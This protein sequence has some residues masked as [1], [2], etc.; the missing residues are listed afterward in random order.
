M[1]VPLRIAVLGE[2]QAGDR[3]LHRDAELSRFVGQ[4]LLDACTGEKEDA[5]RQHIPHLIVAL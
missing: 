2:R 5:D 3:A 1:L 4:V